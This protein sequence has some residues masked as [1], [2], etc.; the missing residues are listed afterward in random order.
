MRK[1]LK[2]KHLK[3]SVDEF[4]RKA[5]YLQVAAVNKLE[6]RTLSYAADRR[7]LKHLQQQTITDEIPYALAAV[8]TLVAVGT[9]AHRTTAHAIIDSNMYGLSQKTAISTYRSV[10]RSDQLRRESA[11]AA[12]SVRCVATV[13]HTAAETASKTRRAG[14]KRHENTD[15]V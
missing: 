6:E 1:I 9:H 12:S 8:G 14:C 13:E 3:R 2:R 15:R 4:P 10:T 7:R 5:V 11:H